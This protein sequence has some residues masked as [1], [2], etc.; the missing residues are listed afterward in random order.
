MQIAKDVVAL[1]HY[2][3][4]DDEGKV[5]DSNQGGEPLH[6]LH[7]HGNLVP[8]LERALEGKQAGDEVQVTVAPAEGYGEYDEQRTFEIPK[9]DLP[10][11]IQPQKGMHLSMQAPTGESVPVTV[12]KVKVGTIVLDGNHPLA[13]KNLHFNVKIQ[14]TRKPS[15]EE[16]A[17]GHAHAPGHHHH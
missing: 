7:G 13:G 12:L 11:H 8:G 14:G 15:K 1:L 2:T 3:L 17:H 9:S 4:K 6:Y 16:L 5:I 10:P